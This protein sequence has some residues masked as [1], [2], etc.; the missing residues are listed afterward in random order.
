MC[1]CIDCVVSSVT[2]SAKGDGELCVCVV[3]SCSSSNLVWSEGCVLLLYGLELVC[4]FV[5]SYSRIILLSTEGEG[6]SRFGSV[7]AGKKKSDARVR[8]RWSPGLLRRREVSPCRF[9]GGG[10]GIISRVE[11]FF[12]KTVEMAS[13]L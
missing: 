9:G 4:C 10:G 1:V 5:F 3:F 7:V 6:P 2:K 12:V 8:V 11:A 13:W